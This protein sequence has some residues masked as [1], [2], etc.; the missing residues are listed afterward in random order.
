M[1]KSLIMLCAAV[2]LGLAGTA[3]GQEMKI[4]VAVQAP[5]EDAL[6]S[7]VAARAPY[8]LIFDGQGV[9]LEALANVAAR[10]KGGAG[11][12]AAELLHGLG[13]RVFVAGRV[14]GRM[15]A[16]L[17]SHTIAIHEKTG[18]AHETVRTIISER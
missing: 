1:K 11:Q 3:L 9:L 17:E 10:A 6:I 15:R 5:Q 18:V 16:A 12:E 13:V 2:L 14:G 7:P 4:G 8:F